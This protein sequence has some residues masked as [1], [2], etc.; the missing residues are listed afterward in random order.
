MFAQS[1]DELNP[2][3]GAAVPFRALRGKKHPLSACIKKIIVHTP[4]MHDDV[5][6]HLPFYSFQPTACARPLMKRR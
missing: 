3:H 2:P 4:D 1:A 6:F 5:L